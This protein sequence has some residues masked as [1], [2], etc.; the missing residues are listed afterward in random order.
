MLHSF[1]L[2]LP[3][4]DLPA[5]STAPSVSAQSV[6]VHLSQRLPDY[7]VPARVLV[8]SQ[9]PLSSNMKVDPR[10]VADLIRAVL[11]IASLNT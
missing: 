11:F 3:L 4:R 5:A 1:L 9:L 2:G 6:R 8:V 7:M 10:L